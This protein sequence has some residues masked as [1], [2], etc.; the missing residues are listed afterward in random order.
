VEFQQRPAAIFGAER[1]RGTTSAVCRTTAPYADYDAVGTD[2]L[3]ELARR[4]I[5]AAS[6]TTQLCKEARPLYFVS[7]MSGASK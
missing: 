7:G 5:P 1:F 6:L 2:A 3:V 4:S